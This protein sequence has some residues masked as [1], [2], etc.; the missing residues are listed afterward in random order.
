MLISLP[1]IAKLV[2][3]FLLF[4]SAN[5]VQ[6]MDDGDDQNA[7]EINKPD[8]IVNIKSTKHKK[9]TKD[10][11]V[12]ADTP[13][14]CSAPYLSAADAVKNNGAYINFNTGYAAQQFVPGG[15]FV[16]SVNAGYNF[17]RIF[18]V[19]GGY[20]GIA[21][22]QYQASQYN[23]V[24]D[25]AVKGT[26]PLTERFSLYGRLGTGVNIMSWNGTAVNA[27]TW[28][29]G[30]NNTTNLLGLAGAGASFALNQ[31]FSLQIEDTLYIP[32]G[33]NTTGQ[34]NLLLGGMQ[35]KF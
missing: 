25:V 30:Q 7:Q 15:G 22:G 35:Y 24:F 16:A 21:S 28:Y 23:N 32:A 6:A 2:F 1:R 18:A 5:L 12:D 33:I 26:L 11:C 34:I 9:S 3:I 19:E 20:T 13:D 27:P 29:C 10:N 31:H 14:S 4:S 8:K 17:S